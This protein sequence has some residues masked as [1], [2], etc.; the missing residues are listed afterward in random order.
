MKNIKER[1][2]ALILSL[3]LLLAMS[4]MGGD[5]IL[6]TSEDHKS[7][8]LVDVNQQTFYVAEMA[9]LEGERYLTNQYNGP[10]STT[11][12]T[13]QTNLRNL[14]QNNAAV[15]DGTMTP[16]NNDKICRNSFND[17]PNDLSVTIAESFNFGTFLENSNIPTGNDQ[18]FLNNFFYEYFIT[19][20]GAAN[21]RGTGSSAK[22]GSGGSGSGK[23]G[24]AYRV[25]G[26]GIYSDPNSNSDDQT[27]VT[28]ESIVILPL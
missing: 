24:M 2:F 28:L 4:L 15:F 20:I 19:R 22:R 16:D 3:V 8:N 9:L 12:H 25:Y 5:L 27:V 18:V 17:L 6:I 21:F 7:N 11:T 23:N 26:C 10:W 13:R 14:P 1:G